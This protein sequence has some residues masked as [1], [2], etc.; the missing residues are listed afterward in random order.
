M[1]TQPI[2]SRRSRSLALLAPTA[3]AALT[4]ACGAVS[5]KT[6]V[7]CSEGSPEN[8]YPGM[9]TTGTSFDVTTQVYNTIVEFERG[10]TKVVPG[11]A[12]KWDISPDGTVYTFHLRKGVKWH[13]TSKSFKPTRDFNA[14]DFIFMIE[15]QWKESDPFFK[16]T[17][18]NHSYFNDMGMPKLLKSVDR[19]DDYTV[20]ITL[21]QAEAPFLANLAMQYAGIQSKEY[22]IA[23]LK[24]GTPEKVDQDPIG[25]G[26]FYL[27]QYQKDAIIRFKAFPQYW[28][29]KAKIDD[30]VFAITPDASVRWAK[31]QKGECHVMPYPNP[32][33]LDAIRKDPNVQV[34]EQPGLNV[35]YLSY[36]TTKKPFDDV[37]VRKAIN[38][39]INK[40]AIIDGVYLSTGVAAKN[41]I[42]P[43]MW[44]YNDAVKDDP[45]D[46]EAAKKLLAQA[47]FPDG[48]S[49]DLW[50]MP[51][52]RPYNPNA[53]RIAELMQADL[54]KINVKAEIKSFEWG[55]YRKRLQ[56]GEHQMG[57]LGWTGDNGDP[58][59]FLYTLLGCASAKSA[60]GS[61]ISKFC[62]QPYEDLVLKAKSATKQSERD[63]L[64][65]KAQLIF[66]EQAPWF[67][68]AHAVQ[69]KPV[70]KEVVDFKLSPFGRH[71]FYGVD[72]K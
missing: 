35:G 70:R 61:N 31:L 60:S 18:Q 39:A 48:F 10:G 41:P 9:N 67:T 62:Y 8:F 71:T 43:T 11:L 27:V 63:A 36:N 7:Y 23:M 12:E 33:D 57:M 13:T 66:K 3:L 17:S 52:Q 64:Y 37:R 44:S 16:V 24:A 65:K 42:P 53:K 72:I 69:L 28:G 20:K 15:R 54:A 50:A 58:D 6:L 38:M 32:A 30:L 40:K 29:G 49:T 51:V 22:A 59:N 26:P 19:I 21:N 5:A 2:V 45:Y 14:D 47:G 25:T 68:I 4:L 34:L 56:A 1:K 55:E 46:P